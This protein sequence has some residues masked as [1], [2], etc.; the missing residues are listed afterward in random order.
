MVAHPLGA[1]A[2]TR[3]TTGAAGDG[4]RYVGRTGRELV[5]RMGVVGESV[6]HVWPWVPVRGTGVDR[7]ALVSGDPTGLR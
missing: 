6:M 7:A 4:W 2:W 3:L 5:H 1:V